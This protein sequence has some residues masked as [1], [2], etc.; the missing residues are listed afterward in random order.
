MAPNSRALA[1]S[2]VAALILFSAPAFAQTAATTAGTVDQTDPVEVNEA[3]ELAEDVDENIDDELDDLLGKEE[4]DKP[5][6]LGASLGFSVGQGTFVS[7]A[8]D[9]Q[10]ADQVGDASRAYDRVSMRFG[11][12]GSYRVQDFSFS[13]SLGFS[14]G[15]TANNGINGSYETRLG[16]LG[17]SA[18]WK[19]WSFEST[20]IS[21]TPSLS[22]ALPTGRTSQV[23]TML[24]STSVGLSL[25]KTFFKRL[26]LGASLGGSRTFHRYTSPVIDI[27]DIGEAN[28]IYR[29]DG[30]EAVEPGRFAVGGINTPYSLTTGLSASMRFPHK[31]SLS[32]GYNLST[33]WSYRVNESDEFSSQYECRGVRCAGQGAAGSVSLSYKVTDWLGASLS[34]RTFGGPRTPDQRSLVFPFW[35]FNGAATNQSTIGL[36]FNGSY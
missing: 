24:L 29:Y 3:E 26:T 9:T 35:N 2:T 21:L 14:Q 13:G 22:V 20:G 27:D 1:S 19:G 18:G 25:S 28:A 31:I 11:V 4:D 8:N 7:V 15:L 5:W 32:I 34:A 30:S 12:S 36:G 17:L 6:S 16:D 33:A 10:W 23:S